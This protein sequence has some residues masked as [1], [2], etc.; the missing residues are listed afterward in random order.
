FVAYPLQLRGAVPVTIL[1][2]LVSL[3]PGTVTVDVDRE[4]GL[5]WIHCL[6]LEDEEALVER[7]RN[8]YEQPLEEVFP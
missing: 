2:S 1:S 4:G 6:D 8:R 5:L 7:I 3:T